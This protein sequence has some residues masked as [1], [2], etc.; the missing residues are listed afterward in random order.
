MTFSARVDGSRS[1]PPRPSYP[2]D[3][4]HQRF[5]YGEKETVRRDVWSGILGSW[6]A[7]PILG[8]A[9]VTFNWKDK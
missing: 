2:Y 9:E 6:G 5:D 8:T 3:I 4:S 1:V 7:S